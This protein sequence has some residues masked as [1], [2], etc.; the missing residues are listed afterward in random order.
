M[1]AV[2]LQQQ[3][4]KTSAK[5]PTGFVLGGTTKMVMLVLLFMLLYFRLFLRKR[6]KDKICSHCG[7]RNPPHRQNCHKCSAPLSDI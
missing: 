7:H 5:S 2:E 6:K 3:P 1:Q 4:S